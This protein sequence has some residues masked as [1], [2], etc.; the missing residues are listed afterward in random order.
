[1]T[2][3]STILHCYCD[4]HMSLTAAPMTLVGLDS[5]AIRCVRDETLPD[6]HV[7]EKK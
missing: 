6:A 2:K 1:M 7:K 3:T 4:E 5:F